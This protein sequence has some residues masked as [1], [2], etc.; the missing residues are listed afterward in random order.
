MFLMVFTASGNKG[1][2]TVKEMKIVW[3]CTVMAGM[4]RNVAQNSSGSVRSPQGCAQASERL[5]PL[6]NPCPSTVPSDQAIWV[7]TLLAL[8]WP[9][10]LVCCFPPPPQEL[11]F[12][13]Y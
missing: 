3:N 13:R 8:F 1:N 6:P 5:C 4:I 7:C 10:T 2:L 11:R 9:H 12:F